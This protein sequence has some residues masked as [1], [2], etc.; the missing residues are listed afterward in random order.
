M[1]NQEKSELERR[2][3]AAL[4]R[5]NANHS[6]AEDMKPQSPAPEQP[7][8]KVGTIQEQGTRE[9]DMEYIAPPP[10]EEEMAKAGRVTSSEITQSA[11][12]DTDDDDGVIIGDTSAVQT[13]PITEDDE[14]LILTSVAKERLGNVNPAD[15]DSFIAGV[16]PEIASYKKDLI[17]NQ[18]MTAAEAMKAATNRM[19]R[20]A[21]EYAE[22]WAKEHP[23]GIVLKVD[24]TQSKDLK[25]DDELEAKMRRS[26]IINLVE[27][28]DRELASLKLKKLPK[29]TKMSNI[30]EIFGSISNFSVPLLSRG[31]YGYF[32]GAQS[33]ALANATAD[34]DDTDL[35]HLEKQA[36]LLYQCFLGS[37]AKSRRKPDGSIMSYEEF[38]NWYH[39]TDIS[40]GLY[41][42]AV[43]SAMEEC[44]TSYVCQNPRCQRVMTTEYNVK[45]LLDLSALNEYYRARLEE[46]D[47]HR[48]NYD[49]LVAMSADSDCA[50]RYKSP[51][52]QNIYDLYSPTIA[53]VRAKLAAIENMRKPNDAT[54][55]MA[56]VY[57]SQMAV[58]DSSDDSYIVVGD[59]DDLVD[60]FNTVNSLHNVD[61]ELIGK[62]FLQ[63]YYQPEY[64][65]KVKC[66]HCGVERVDPLDVDAMLFLLARA[67]FTAIQ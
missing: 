15:R 60:L 52:S 27:V 56:Y 33:S 4:E 35:D 28:E 53:Q 38:C 10:T 54:N 55:V 66:P 11:A 21:N 24:M 39:F 46:I 23:E 41:A 50:H 30:R 65:L 63:R 43:A 64:K 49:H 17:I 2:A 36:S 8:A 12:T 16:M 3:A 5:M 62:A 48:S 6:S 18:G 19:K 67:S 59:E 25:F 29:E 7:S 37:V 20:S 58:H 45:S 22:N 13:A 61:L 51:F 1:P 40:I 31:D 44:E 47:A 32:C 57:L 9:D 26:K 34:E 14:T 42:V